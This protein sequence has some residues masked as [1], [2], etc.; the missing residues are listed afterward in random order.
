MFSLEKRRLRED[1]IP[2]YSYLNGGCSEVGV[3]LFF[4]GTSDRIR[5]DSHKLHQG[6][7]RLD[8]KKK[9]FTGRVVKHWNRLLREVVKSLSLEIFKDG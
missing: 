9:I 3:G 2:L 7:F 1:L 4:Q 6:R 8:S 5:G